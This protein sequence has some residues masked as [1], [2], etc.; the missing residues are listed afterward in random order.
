MIKRQSCIVAL[1][2]VF[3]FQSRVFA[4]IKIGVAMGEIDNYLALLRDAIEARGKAT[5]GVTLQFQNGRADVVTQLNQV[6][7]FIEEK[8]DALIV[9][10]VDTAA[11]RNI[12]K[13]AV[14]AKIPLIYCNRVPKES[15]LP[16][17]V[18]VVASPD[19]TAGV[20][21]MEYLAEK[22][23]G[24]GNVAIIMGELGNTSTL[25]RTRGMEDVITRFP[26]LKVIEKQTAAFNR[27]K[28]L[29][30]VS[31]WIFTGLEIDAIASNNDEMA[32]GAAMALRQ[33]SKKNVLIGGLDG[34]RDG[35]AAVANGTLTVSVFQD[36]QGQGTG[37]VDSALELIK[38]EPLGTQSV[39]VPYRLITPNN[40]KKFQ[41]PQATSTAQADVKVTK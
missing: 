19:H 5:P 1:L 29:D 18:V 2:L 8:V 39:I 3:V 34:T 26:G 17:G 27:D 20:M 7:S 10:P 21:Q 31:G 30:L 28:A 12:T 38:H 23:G 22:L 14:A 6:Q 41:N 33:A 16:D 32:I 37:A 15:P 36:A 40:V 24:K 11:T 4:D 13:A 25:E 35:L 9:L